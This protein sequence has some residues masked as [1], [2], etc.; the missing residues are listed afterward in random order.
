[1]KTWKLP[2]SILV[3][4]VI[5]SALAITVGGAWLE[6][7]ELDTALRAVIVLAAIVAFSVLGIKS[8]MEADNAPSG[9]VDRK[10]DYVKL[11]IGL[12][13]TALP[14][15]FF[16]IIF[17][18]PGI[19]GGVHGIVDLYDRADPYAAPKIDVLVDLESGM[20]DEDTPAWV[21][22]DISVS[23]DKFE[24]IRLDSDSLPKNAAGPVPGNV[25]ATIVMESDAACD[26][27]FLVP[28]DRVRGEIWFVTS[29]PEDD[30]GESWVEPF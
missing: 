15:L 23:A 13:A 4:Y 14:F 3:V 10:I 8:I 19:L 16:I 18:P 26:F 5:L 30:R 7:Q 17:C 24:L 12:V 22:G 6:F 29:D 21:R 25:Y 28:I 11:V 9:T 20:N 1:M 27:G 2:F